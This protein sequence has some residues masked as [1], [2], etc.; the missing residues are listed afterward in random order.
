MKLKTSQPNPSHE[1]ELTHEELRE[2]L[3]PYIRRML[4]GAPVKLPK[5]A[6][7]S[8]EAVAHGSQS[9]EYISLDDSCGTVTVKW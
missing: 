4:K 7:V 6:E 9:N 2:A 3:L 1:L 8:I 5:G